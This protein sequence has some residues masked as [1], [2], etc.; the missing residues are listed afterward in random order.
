[1]AAGFLAGAATFGAAGL[2]AAAAVFVTLVTLVALVA[3]AA[4]LAGAFSPPAAFA[5]AVF[6]AAPA[7]VVFAIPCSIVKQTK[8]YRRFS[9]AQEGPH[10]RG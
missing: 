6:A 2:R 8:Q 5:R 4:V 7:A 10:A 9:A 1:L 3:F